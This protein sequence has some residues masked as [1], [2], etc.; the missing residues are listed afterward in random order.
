LPVSAAGLEP[1]PL[2][3][4]ARPGDTVRQP[5]GSVAGGSVA[6]STPS[7]VQ[8]RMTSSAVQLGSPSGSAGE[9]SRVDPCSPRCQCS[10]GGVMPSGLLSGQVRKPVSRQSQRKKTRWPCRDCRQGKGRTAWQ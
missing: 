2:Q 7:C 9:W 5:E 1:E 10:G 3:P 8:N 6:A 4:G